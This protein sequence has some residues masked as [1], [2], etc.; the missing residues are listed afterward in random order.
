MCGSTCAAA[1]H[2]HRDVNVEIVVIARSS[3]SLKHMSNTPHV[4]VHVRCCDSV[5]IQ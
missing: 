4:Y 5:V 3:N 1:V 2:V